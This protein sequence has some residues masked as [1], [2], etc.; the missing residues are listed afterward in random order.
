MTVR[1]PLALTDRQ[2]GT[3][4]ALC[5]LPIDPYWANFAATLS[6]TSRRTLPTLGAR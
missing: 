6:G 2:L 3:V 1:R 5:V 4:I